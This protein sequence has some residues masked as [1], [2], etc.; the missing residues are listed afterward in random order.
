[1]K[2][3]LDKKTAMTATLLLY[4][5]VLHIENTGTLFDNN[6]RNSFVPLA[7]PRS[8]VGRAPDS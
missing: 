5:M 8:A 7:E 1:M 6:T 2:V 3:L 4:V